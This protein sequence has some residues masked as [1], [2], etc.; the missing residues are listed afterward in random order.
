MVCP[1]CGTDNAADARLC[2]LCGELLPVAGTPAAP[3]PGRARQEAAERIEAR[4]RQDRVATI[5]LGIGLL[6]VAGL[7]G[8]RFSTLPKAV[9]ESREQIVSDYPLATLDAYY[10]A[11]ETG[12]YAKAHA[13]LCAAVQQKVPASAFEAAFATGGEPKPTSHKAKD[14]GFWTETH[15]FTALSV[16]GKRAYHTLVKEPEGWRIEWTPLVGRLLN[17]PPPLEPAR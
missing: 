11:L 3:A 2:G 15:A 12:D 6:A 4:R 10:Q 5:V 1:E 16:N 14:L 13:M 17:V 7:I 8:W 9:A